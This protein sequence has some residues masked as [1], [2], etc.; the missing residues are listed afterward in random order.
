LFPPRSSDRITTQLDYGKFEAKAS[1]FRAEMKPAN[2][3]QPAL[4]TTV[5]FYSLNAYRFSYD[6]EIRTV[7]KRFG[8]DQ[9]AVDTQETIDYLR[10]HTDQLE[11][12]GEID[13]WRDDLIRYGIDRLTG[14]SSDPN[15]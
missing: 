11:L 13:A 9:E 7:L 12:A 6:T 4:N 3:I 1:P 2:S 5:V 10:S 14:D 15:R 8:T